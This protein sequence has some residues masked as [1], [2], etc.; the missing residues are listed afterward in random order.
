MRIV[1]IGGGLA[2]LAAAIRLQEQRHDVVLLERRGVLGGRATSARD[3]TTGDVVDNGM[4]VM[5]GAYDATL[6]L[7]RRAGAEDLL[8]RQDSLS[9][10]YVD[11]RGHTR[12]ACPPLIAPLHLLV[13]LS[14]LRL[15]L[16]AR[17]Q[18][19]RFGVA[20]GWGRRP[21]GVTLAEYLARHG[22][23]PVVRGLLWD[24]LA[25]AI[26]NV[27]PETGDAGLFVECLRRAFFRRAASSAMVFLRAGF[28]DLAER[29]GRY[30]ESRGGQ[31][32]RRACAAAIDVRDGRV[33]AVRCRQRP[34]GQEEIESGVRAHDESIVAD[35]VVCAVPWNRVTTL[36]PDPWRA[37]PP[38]VELGQLGASPIVSVDLWLD[39][40]VVDGV[41]VGL[42][43]CEMEWVFDKGALHG[44]QGAP[45][46][47][48]FIL[49]A[50]ERGV[51]RTNTEL[52]AMAEAALRRFYPRM[53]AARVVRS[54]VRREPEATFSCVPA[55][56]ALRPGP[57][58][59]I[60]GL[61][62]AGDWT[63]TGLPATIEGAVASGY[64]AARALAARPARVDR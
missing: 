27:A 52:V 51:A 11:A 39:R 42:R 49:S 7:V 54:L 21:R 24:P 31:V 20:L 13:G 56:E 43:E 34:L 59:P 16:S 46:Y 10:D 3:T 60:A 47:L 61:Y 19:L 8:L 50:A 41:M 12:L 29:L 64:A 45:Q 18:A 15:P 53:R 48:S 14:R 58:T 23:G 57:V 63:N 55:H 4:H 28:G 30:L 35:A 1:V 26:L 6:D 25:T 5:L 32:R 17:W 2:G 40:T 33:A 36:V 62:L 9:I 37:A 38:F 22:Q 44:R